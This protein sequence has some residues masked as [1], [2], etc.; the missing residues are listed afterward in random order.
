DDALGQHGVGHLGEA[1]D[2]GARHQVAL[3]A[4]GLGS[5]GGVGVDVLHDVLQP[6]VHLFKGPGQP[7]RVLAHL[8][9]AGGHAAGVGSLGRGEQHAVRLQVGHRVGG[10]R[11]VGAFGHRVAAARNQRFGAFQR[12]FVL[13]GAG[14]GDVAGHVPDALAAL[15]ILGGGHIVQVGLDAGALDLLDLLH[16]LVVDAVLV[17]NVAVGIAHRNDLAAQLGGLLV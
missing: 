13:G 15:H 17:H 5:L 14:Q 4:V 11:H 10:G 2:V 3:H 6:V 9:A 12:Q 8:Q 16:Q 1:G 7:Q